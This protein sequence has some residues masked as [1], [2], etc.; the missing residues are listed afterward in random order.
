MSRRLA[1][2]LA[3]AAFLAGL[4]AGRIDLPEAGPEQ[5]TVTARR[6]DTALDPATRRLLQRYQ[7]AAARCPR[8]EGSR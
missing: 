8:R 2:L 1:V 5:V 4:G 3:L 7:A 6:S